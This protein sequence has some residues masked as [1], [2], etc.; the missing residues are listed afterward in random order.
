MRGKVLAAGPAG[1][2]LRA[3]GLYEWTLSARSRAA[4]SGF[5]LTQTNDEGNLSIAVARHHLLCFE[6]DPWGL[7]AVSV[8]MEQLWLEWL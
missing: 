2:L 7:C 6:W 4:E 3:R 5:V 1:A 8:C